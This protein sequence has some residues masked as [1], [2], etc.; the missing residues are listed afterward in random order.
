MIRTKYGGTETFMEFYLP[1]CLG[2]LAIKL[3]QPSL[4][5][6]PHL[7]HSA[8]CHKLEN[9]PLRDN[10]IVQIEAAILPLHRTIDVQCIAQ[11]EVGRASGVGG[12]SQDWPPPT[13]ERP[14]G[15]AAGIPL[16]LPS[17]RTQLPHRAWNSLVQ[18]EWVICSMESQ[19]QCV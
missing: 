12:Q 7:P 2:G 18:S 15:R 19:R 14:A 8:S 16:A 6:K 9:L 13:R 1:Y 5:K 3:Y 4:A 11:P 17:P 10:S